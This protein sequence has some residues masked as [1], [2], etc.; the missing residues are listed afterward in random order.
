MDNDRIT[1][2]M[3][4]AYGNLPH[5]EHNETWTRDPVNMS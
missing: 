2:I 1:V 5:F 3:N 4:E